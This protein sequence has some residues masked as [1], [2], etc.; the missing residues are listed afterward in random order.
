V[1]PNIHYENREIEGERL[2]LPA[3][4]IY[5]LGPNVTL[6]RCTLVIGVASRW[7]SLVSGRLI[8]CTIEAKRELVDARWTTL[9][10]KGC[11]FSGRF[12]GN[13]FGHRQDYMDDW[14][15]GGVEDCDFSEARLDLCRFHGCDMRTV[16]LPKWPGFTIV[17]P[18]RHGRELMSVAWPGTF[19]PVILEGPLKELPSTVALSFYAP[20]E[21]KR[22]RTTEAELKAAV[23]RFDFIVR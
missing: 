11:R 2:E 4:A 10:F 17:D 22:S 23:E 19:K 20:A 14:E 9:G 5:W 15:L 21:A 6:R 1:T 7:L 16:R 13:E 3:G 8:D 12:C 18:L